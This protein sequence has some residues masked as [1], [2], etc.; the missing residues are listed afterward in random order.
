LSG[1]PD[2]IAFRTYV[3][4]RCNRL[5]RF[6]RWAE[7]LGVADPRPADMRSWWGPIVMDGNVEQSGFD[8][9][10]DICPVDIIEAD[11]TRRC[12]LALPNHLRDT[13]IQE[14]VVCG[15]QAQKARALGIHVR[16]Y[17]HRLNVAHTL[18]LDLFNA[19]AADL[20][21]EVNYQPPGRPRK[22][23]SQQS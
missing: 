17:R 7:G 18:L 21:L 22:H 10:R 6:A 19:V 4:L 12:I 8:S 23:P 9:L 13:I 20:P 14:Y 3:I 15:K 5:G 11:E 16:T 2:D 1:I